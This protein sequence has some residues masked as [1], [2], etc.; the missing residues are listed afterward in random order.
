VLPAPYIHAGDDE[1][2]KRKRIKTSFSPTFA[3][4]YTKINLSFGS[5][6]QTA[7]S[8]ACTFLHA[9]PC[10]QHQNVF[11]LFNYIFK[12]LLNYISVNLTQFKLLK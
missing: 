4:R 11:R 1:K 2:L 9:E 3:I 10:Q 7:N 6:M 5:S 8:T 12:L